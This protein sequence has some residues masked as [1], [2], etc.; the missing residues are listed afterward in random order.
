MPERLPIAM[1]FC[2][3]VALVTDAAHPHAASAWCAGGCCPGWDV[4]EDPTGQG[5]PQVCGSEDG[6]LTLQS[7]SHRVGV[8][9]LFGVPVF[10]DC[11]GL[12]G[13]ML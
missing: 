3:L 12:S 1:L 2:L 9:W 8:R 13:D 4:R 7:A 10:T 6:G 11:L 5:R